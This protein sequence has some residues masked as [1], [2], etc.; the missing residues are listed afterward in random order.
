M[1]WKFGAIP[2]KIG[3][4]PDKNNFKCPVGHLGSVC[5]V[6]SVDAEIYQNCFWNSRLDI[7]DVVTEAA[8][9]HAPLTGR[10]LGTHRNRTSPGLLYYSF[11]QIIPITELVAQFVGCLTPRGQRVTR[12]QTR[13]G[14]FP[15]DS[16]LGLGFLLKHRVW[17]ISESLKN[18]TLFLIFFYKKMHKPTVV[19][20]CQ[21]LSLTNT[22][23]FFLN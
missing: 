21:L 10:S 11:V 19:K 5:I 16:V 4:F 3:S 20:I 13:I 2:I 8:M 23:L 1:C 18:C 22:A 15:R 9:L 17:V 14:F 12:T 7:V 6:T